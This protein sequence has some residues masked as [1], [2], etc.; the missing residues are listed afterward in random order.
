MQAKI[1]PITARF[2]ALLYLISRVPRE[3]LLGA[4]KRTND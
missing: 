4:E 1:A 2:I 3:K